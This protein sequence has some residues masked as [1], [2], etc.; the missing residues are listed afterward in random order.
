MRP[1]TRRHRMIPAQ[2]GDDRSRSMTA[3]FA[4][5]HDHEATTDLAKA[6][7]AATMLRT[8]GAGQVRVPMSPARIAS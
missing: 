8:T 4:Y 1:C 7:A 6:L 3:Y 2:V 5:L